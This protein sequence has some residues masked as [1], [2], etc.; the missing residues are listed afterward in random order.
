MRCEES[1]ILIGSRGILVLAEINS[2][3]NGFFCPNV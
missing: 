2:K 1:V 3:K